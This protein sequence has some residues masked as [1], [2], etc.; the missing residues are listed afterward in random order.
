MS[1]RQGI[2]DLHNAG[3]SVKKIKNLLKVSISTVCD[4]VAR[5]KELG[6]AKDRPRSGR[7]RSARTKENIKAVR[8]RVRRNPKQSMR[9]MANQMKMDPKSMRTIV[10]TDLKLSP[11][12]LRK[13]Q[14]LTVLQK[15][16]R[17]DRSQLLINLMKS[18]T[19]EGEIAFSYE[20]LFNHQ[21]D[22]VLPKH[23]ADV[24][25]DILTVNRRQ[26]PAFVM[27]WAAVSKTWKSPLISVRGCEGEYKCVHR[28][29]FDSCSS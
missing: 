7:P 24:S 1:K 17:V 5:Y 2:I 6:N 3:M 15:K 4:A 22:R 23:S 12:K 14:H 13:R 10:K 20:K 21:N 29:N 26:K 25:E 9:K 18:D 28:R 11:L 8:E 27:V 16:K 19:R